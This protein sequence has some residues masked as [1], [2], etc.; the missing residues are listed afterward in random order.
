LNRH[1]VPTILNTVYSHDPS[2]SL[3]NLDTASLK[4]ANPLSVFYLDKPSREL[5]DQVVQGSSRLTAAQVPEFVG[6]AAAILKT[7]KAREDNNKDAEA[8]CSLNSL[9]MIFIF[10]FSE[11]Q[12]FSKKFIKIFKQSIKS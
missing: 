2:A 11:N 1:L 8:V 4:F 3:L 12:R 5:V 6:L 9:I 10:L 7:Y